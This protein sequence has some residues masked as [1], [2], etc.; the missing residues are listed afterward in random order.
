[1]TE[2]IYYLPADKKTDRPILAVIIGKES[3]L[4]VDAGNSP[5][6]AKL[7]L[8]EISKI[9]MPQ[10]GYLV[11]THWHWDHIFGIT[12]MNLPT[13]AHIETKKKIEELTLLDW[14]D[15]ALD[16]RVESGEEVAF[17][18]DMIKAEMP[19][20]SDLQITPP[21]ITFTNKMEIDL[22]G[23]HCIIENV[24][25]DHSKDSSVIYVS[26]DK[27]LFLGDCI[28]GDVYNNWN[29]SSENIVMM[30]EK[31]KSYDVD[32]YVESHEIPVSKDKMEEE[33]NE[34]ESMVN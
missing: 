9:E 1:M 32:Y 29:Y 11:I 33:F 28:C 27:T 7:F 16:Q 31:L 3:Y 30:L 17:C 12:T 15:Q 19:D 18:S 6:H 14:S 20:R 4:V 25:G 23:V 10:T 13:I 34:L 5:A 26:E 21:N 8:D 24:A 2:H 22:G